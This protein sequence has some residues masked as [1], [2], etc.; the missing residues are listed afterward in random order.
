MRKGV[1]K[2]ILIVLMACSCLSA[3]A[4]GDDDKKLIKKIIHLKIE[5]KNAGKIV[6]A[7]TKDSATNKQVDD[8]LT[9]DEKKAVE[10]TLTFDDNKN[11]DDTL[12]FADDEMKLKKSPNN[13][14]GPKEFSITGSQSSI[15]LSTVIY[16]NPS[17]GQS[18]L[19]MN[20]PDNS[21]TEI[22]IT[23][24]D[25]TLIRKESTIGKN[26]ELKDLAAGTYLV[27]IKNGNQLVQKRLFVK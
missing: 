23:S 21:V 10:D 1:N 20:T 3:S 6:K 26:Y 27:T 22:I 7:P 18:I 11:V 25:G 15:G 14:N 8:T 2:W 13:Q 9:F 12:I 5:N 24:Q 16:P 19:E 17:F 4:F